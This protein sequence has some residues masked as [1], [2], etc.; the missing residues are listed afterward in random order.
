M[1]TGGFGAGGVLARVAPRAVK[2]VNATKR[3]AELT[4]GGLNALTAAGGAASG[5]VGQAISDG[6][7]GHRSSFGDYV[8][9]AGGARSAP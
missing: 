4:P 6:L 8:G 2:A 5:V 1:A 9:A 7:S 3:I